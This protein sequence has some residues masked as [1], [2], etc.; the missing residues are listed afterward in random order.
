MFQALY[1][2]GKGYFWKWGWNFLWGWVF[3]RFSVDFVEIV[4]SEGAFANPSTPPQKTL[5]K[6]FQTE[7]APL[8][9]TSILKK[10]KYWD[11]FGEN[12]K[13]KKKY[14]IVWRRRFRSKLSRQN[15]RK[16]EPRFNLTWNSTPF[17][18]I[19]CTKPVCVRSIFC[20]AKAFIPREFLWALRFG[21][22]ISFK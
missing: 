11:E 3:L 17:S 7:V 1:R 4:S 14:E 8:V 13:N 19:P 6:Y 18:K 22:W 16:I 2:R 10:N 20:T 9:E 5:I 15:H 12:L 21:F